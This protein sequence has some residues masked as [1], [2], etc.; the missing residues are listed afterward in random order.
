MADLD[1]WHVLAEAELAATKGSD[2][3]ARKQRQIAEKVETQGKKRQ[4]ED[5]ESREG[6]GG[7]RVLSPKHN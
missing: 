4:F 6:K 7:Y 5:K 1:D 3:A 2:K